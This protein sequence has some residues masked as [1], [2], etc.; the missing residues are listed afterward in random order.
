M[1]TMRKCL[2]SHIA[3]C[4]QCVFTDLLFQTLWYCFVARAQYQIAT[5]HW[6][7]MGPFETKAAESNG[8][9]KHLRIHNSRCSRVHGIRASNDTICG[10]KSDVTRIVFPPGP[11]PFIGDRFVQFFIFDWCS[12]YAQLSHVIRKPTGSLGCRLNATEC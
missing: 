8:Q 3:L 2:D 4:P 12:L 5:W 6:A 10:Q 9:L 7:E 11:S 1:V